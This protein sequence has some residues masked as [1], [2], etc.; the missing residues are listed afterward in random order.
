MLFVNHLDCLPPSEKKNEMQV[1]LGELSLGMYDTTEQIL[2][3]EQVIIHEN[4]TETTGFVS[5][6][7]GDPFTLLSSQPNIHLDIFSL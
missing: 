5:S 2:P 7:I 1:V 4:Y 6:D 3:V